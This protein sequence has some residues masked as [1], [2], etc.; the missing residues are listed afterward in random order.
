L[1]KGQSEFETLKLICER[2][3]PLPSQVRPGYPAELEKIVMK[4]LSKER[5]DRYQT[6]R[7]MQGDIETFVRAERIAVSTIAL[8]QFM[9]TL[10]EDMLASQ[11]EQLLQGKQLADIIA[12]QES[13][14]GVDHGNVTNTGS[15]VISTASA[16]RTI[17]GTDI[18]RSS[19][20]GWIVAAALGVAL[21]GGGI[22]GYVYWKKH[23]TTV[24]SGNLNTPLAP[25]GSIEITSD[26][27]GASI[28]IDGDLRPEQTPATIPQLPL[29]KAINIKLTMDGFESEKK[30]ITITDKKLKEAV[31][32]KLAKGS[33][34]VDLTVLPDSAKPVAYLDS[35]KQEGLTLSNIA[36]GDQHK[37]EV[38]ADGFQS[39]STTFIG[40]PQEKKHFDVTLNKEQHF[41]V[42]VGTG[43][44]PAAPV[45]RGKLNVDAKGGWCNITIDGSFKGPTPLA[46]IDLA[47][48]PHTVTCTPEGGR[49]QTATVNVPIDG[50]GRHK[51]SL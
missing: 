4:A 33:V 40:Q 18:S 14:S 9:Q 43:V 24:V 38:K 12:S 46:G 11:K 22:G 34:V 42:P 5:G 6:A 1:F 16:T 30:N 13:L 28:W 20:V 48:G 35:K 49:P 10:F 29:G 36:S 7:E 27:P 26:P 23:K 31:S 47:S 17:S 51:F 45:G 15:S 50:V 25:K 41:S 21:I 2:E 39:W 19:S 32:F 3:Y 8:Q 37:L 44:K